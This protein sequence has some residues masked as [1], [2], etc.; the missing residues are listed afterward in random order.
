MWLVELPSYGRP[1]KSPGRGSYR[2][3]QSEPRRHMPV[4]TLSSRSW[5]LIL[6]ADPGFLK[7]G[8]TNLAVSQLCSGGHL[9]PIRRRF[10]GMGQVN[11]GRWTGGWRLG[12]LSFSLVQSVVIPQS[13]HPQ[14][15]LFPGDAVKMVPTPSSVFF[16]EQGVVLPPTR[17]IGFVSQ[18]CFFESCRVCPRV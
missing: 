5:T 10:I 11:S 8:P 17:H 16:Y 13:R 1:S 15:Q 3:T 6:Q 2:Q 4:K 12:A 14:V 18:I 7:V 9:M